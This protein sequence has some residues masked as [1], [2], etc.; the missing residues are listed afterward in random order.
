MVNLLFTPD[1]EVLRTP[2]HVRTLYDPACGTGGM[3]S[4]AEEFLRELNPDARLEVFGQDYNNEAFAICC[5]DMMIKGQHPDNI[6]FGDSFTDDGLARQEVRLPAGQSALRRRVEAPGRQV[7]RRSTRSKGFDGRFGPG[8]PRI[9]DGSLLFIMHMISKMK[10]EGC[11]AL[12]IVFNG[13]PLFTGDAGSGE[14][15]IRRWIIE[16]DWLEAIVALPDRD[17]LQHRHR[18]LYMDTHQPQAPERRGKVQLINATDLYVKMRKSLGNKRNELSDGNI[19]EIV[20]LYGD[21]TKN[22]RSKL[23]D[24][25]DFGYQPDHGR[26]SSQAGIPSDARAHRG[27]QGRKR[28]PKTGNSKKKGREGQHEIEAGQVLQP[29]IE[30]MLKAMDSSIVDKNR[31][32][33]EERLTSAIDQAGIRIP[34]PV[35]KAIFNVMSERDESAEICRDADGNPEPDTELRDYENVP[36]KENIHDYFKREVL[37]ACP[38]CVDRRIENAR[39]L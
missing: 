27:A 29:E 19:A 17:V 38:R 31:P 9:N 28:L 15:E 16:S 10:P 8:L 35:R 30:R 24:N 36:L 22:G 7:R 4:V 3:L 5:S 12:A 39:W 2:G 34:A 6:K 1:S 32:A 21:L 23:F 14:S 37:A 20:D 33:F 18:H 25:T 26:A 11:A 13:S